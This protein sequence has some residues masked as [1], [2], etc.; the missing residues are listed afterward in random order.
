MPET[1]DFEKLMGQVEVLFCVYIWDKAY[2][3]FNWF[4]SQF[5]YLYVNRDA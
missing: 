2:E 5:V 4:T 1:K 3:S